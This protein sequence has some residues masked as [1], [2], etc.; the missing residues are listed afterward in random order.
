M[1]KFVQ[2]IK[3]L[4]RRKPLYTWPL[5]ITTRVLGFT[6]LRARAA[7]RATTF[8]NSVIGRRLDMTVPLTNLCGGRSSPL[9]TLANCMIE[10]RES[11]DFDALAISASILGELIILHSDLVNFAKLVS[12]CPAGWVAFFRLLGSVRPTQGL[13]SRFCW[14]F[15]STFLVLTSMGVLMTSGALLFRTPNPS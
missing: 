7:L 11:S 14:F 8:S 5:L 9:S 12:R 6:R 10:C 13:V 4:T 3:E 15:L 2:Q 1:D